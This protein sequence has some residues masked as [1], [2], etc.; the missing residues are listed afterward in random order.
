M[1]R[2]L[3]I[4]II[5]LAVFAC[6]KTEFS[7]EGPTDVRIRN[8]S[9]VVFNE[10]IIKTSEYE[11]DVDTIANIN[12]GSESEYF[13][14]KKAYPKAEIT[15]KI[16]IGGTISTFSTGSVNFTYLTYIGQDKI[17]FEVYISNAET[18]ELTINNVVLDEPLVLK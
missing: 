15:A 7:P 9:D 12:A 13:R 4:S 8:L 1:K 5:I 11:E 17:T 18:K 3:Q 16:N 2:L 10:V 6:K 14:F